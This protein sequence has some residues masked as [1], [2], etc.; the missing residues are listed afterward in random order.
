MDLIISRFVKRTSFVTKYLR[1]MKAP[2]QGLG[3][4]LVINKDPTKV[5]P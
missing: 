3:T 4:A 1:G 5:G 2:L